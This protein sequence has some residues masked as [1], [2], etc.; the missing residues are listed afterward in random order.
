[1]LLLYIDNI[2]KNKIIKEDSIGT[3]HKYGE[4]WLASWL[5][6]VQSLE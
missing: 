1:M 5:L 4:E 6:Y 3:K 2:D